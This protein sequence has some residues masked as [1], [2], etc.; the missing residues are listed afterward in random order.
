[1][2]LTFVVE[3]VLPWAIVLGTL[4]RRIAA[5]AFA[6]LL[7]IIAITGNYGF[8]D[9]LA[10]ALVISLVDDDALA[11]LRRVAPEASRP[12]VPPRAVVGVLA[13]AQMLLGVLALLSTLGARASFPGAVIAI[14]EAAD[15][16]RVAN[17]YGLFAVM[18]RERPIV[19]FEGS[20][21]GETWREYDYRWQSGDP[22][23]PPAVSTPHMPR[24]DWMIWFA[25]LRGE[26]EGWIVA[27]EIGLLEAR[28]DV[29]ALFGSDPFE[30]RRP[31]YVRSVRYDYRFAPRGQSD[32]WI[33]SERAAFGP[34]LESR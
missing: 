14:D 10:L 32:W 8:F 23:R 27:T 5:S 34:T 20:E 22:A 18:T 7:A 11:H 26:P 30:G 17:G 16:F 12:P 13:C 4:G 25:G 31:R 19:I 9:L 29:L 33:R 6:L 21:D 1:M 3:L 15:P 28:P 2:A 24:L